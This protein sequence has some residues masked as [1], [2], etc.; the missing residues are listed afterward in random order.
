MR[1]RVRR[2][3]LCELVRQSYGTANQLWRRGGGRVRRGFI[4]ALVGSSGAWIGLGRSEQ[5]TDQGRVES[6]CR[7]GG[8]RGDPAPVTL[9][10]CASC[11]LAVAVG[12][13]LRGCSRSEW[14][15]GKKRGEISGVPGVTKGIFSLQDFKNA[16]MRKI[17]VF[18]YPLG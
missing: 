8:V 6:E 2:R 7:R 5:E 15:V 16:V 14:S 13:L 9:R 10:W 11:C 12:P 18:S 1:V 3:G 17:V 4:A